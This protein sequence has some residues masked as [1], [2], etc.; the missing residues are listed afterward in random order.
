M[1][2][3]TYPLLQEF[4]PI[5]RPCFPPCCIRPKDGARGSSLRFEEPRKSSKT[6]RRLRFL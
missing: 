3:S 5:P 2:Q 1:H 4:P 6:V